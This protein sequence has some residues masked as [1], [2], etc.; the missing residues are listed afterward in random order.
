VSA[1]SLAPPINAGRGPSSGPRVLFSH[2][3]FA[4]QRYGGV[5]RYVA[6]LHASLL[7]A[8]VDARVF[9]GL[10][11]NEYLD[12]ERS[13]VGRRIPP[14]SRPPVRHAVRLLNVAAERGLVAAWKP[15]AYHVSYY[16]RR[17]PRLRAP[18]V[19]TVYDMIHERFPE[20][21]RPQDRTSEHKRWWVDAASLVFVPSER[22]RS[23]LLDLWPACG[24]KVVMLRP[25][26]MPLSPPA[27]G[28]S[29]DFDDYL[30]F[31]GDRR[32]PYKNFAR[33]IEAVARSEHGRDCR[34]VCFGGGD[35]S[36]EE[37]RSLLA[38]GLLDR[39][40]TIAGDDAVLAGLYRDAKAL[41]YPSRYEGFGFPL[42]EAMSLG[43]P[44]TC[45]DAGPLPEVA[46]GAAL[47]FDP[48][49]TE[50]IAAAIDRV[51]TDSALAIKLRKAG[52]RR[53][54]VYDWQLAGREARPYYELLGP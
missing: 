17:R 32:A 2:D 13:V 12:G 43:C 6:H 16:S 44:V 9:G 53:A 23:D 26:I 51:L 36:H 41:V 28:P 50:S 27:A 52:A 19:V 22:T 37:R 54:E 15:A 35:L 3:I 18:V 45:S 40:H 20:Q 14:P 24:P 4:I 38:L 46:A 8:G 5:S 21:F 34:L 30:L 49:D 10:H 47:T 39:T 7:A 11:V 1:T 48:D 33:L 31:V 29:G 25:G 42:I